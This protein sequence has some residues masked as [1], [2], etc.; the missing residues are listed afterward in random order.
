MQKILG[1]V[2]PGKGPQLRVPIEAKTIRAKITGLKQEDAGVDI[3][4]VHPTG[5]STFSALV[6]GIID[7]ALG[8]F[9]RFE[10][11]GTS[12]ITCVLLVS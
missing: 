5:E 7:L 6:D 8:S 2:G 3:T 10:H 9:V 1:L 12:N 4:V 11:N